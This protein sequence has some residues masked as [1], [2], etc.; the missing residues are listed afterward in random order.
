MLPSEGK[1]REKRKASLLSA[2]LDRHI[3]AYVAAAASAGIISFALPTA[4]EIVYTPANIPMAVDGGLGPA[5]TPLD[6]NNDGVPD[7]QFTNYIYSTHGLG[8]SYLKVA[9]AQEGNEIWGAKIS[10]NRRVTAAVLP[11]GMQVGSKANFHSYPQGLNMAYRGHGTQSGHAS[12]GWL[13]VETAFLGFKFTISGEVH[14]GWVLVKFPGPGQ[15]LSGSIAGYAYE[16]IPN[17]PIVTGKTSGTESKGKQTSEE[18]SDG[19]ASLG[20][21]ATGARGIPL[22]RVGE[23]KVAMQPKKLEKEL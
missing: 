13:K 12:G 3:A 1:L 5:Y 17:Q 2:K 8:E 7:F 21:L 10:S 22:W 19:G 16:T 20:W 14:Y 11:P 9:P 15:F 23:D 6:L 4:A 18:S